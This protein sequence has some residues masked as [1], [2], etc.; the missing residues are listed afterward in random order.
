M[1]NLKK[2]HWNRVLLL[3][4]TM[5]GAIILLVLITNGFTHHNF[6]ISLKVAGFI[7]GIILLI[8]ISAMFNPSTPTIYEARHSASRKEFIN[9]WTDELSEIAVSRN[10]VEALFGRMYDEE[11]KP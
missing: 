2:I 3:M 4:S 5:T 10:K 7:D 8:A 1:K 11:I 9:K 6:I